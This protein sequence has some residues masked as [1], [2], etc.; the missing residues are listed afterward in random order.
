MEK[1]KAKNEMTKNLKNDVAD[2]HGVTV[3]YVNMC[4]RGDR[5]NPSIV[6]TYDMLK[7]GKSKLVEAVKKAVQ[8][9]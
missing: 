7:Y 2:I 5:N 6:A 8:L 4:L 1:D 9:N 3:Q